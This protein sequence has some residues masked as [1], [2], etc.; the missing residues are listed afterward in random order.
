M[1]QAMQH[2]PCRFLR[3]ANITSQ[4]RAGDALFVA[5]EKPNGNEPLA[6]RE[7]SIF[8]NRTDFDRKPFAAV[9]A[10]MGATV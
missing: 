3:Y 9:T 4:L 10:F 1:A 7:L 8:E 2:E 5:R 6:E